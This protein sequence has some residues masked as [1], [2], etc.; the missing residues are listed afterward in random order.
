[1]DF[2]LLQI[3]GTH[4]LPQ[5]VKYQRPHAEVEEHGPEFGEDSGG[6]VEPGLDFCRFKVCG[7]GGGGGGEEGK[8]RRP[9][10]VN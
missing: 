9:R 10:R 5:A 4:L 2:L 7:G 6:E 1:M 8:R 3:R